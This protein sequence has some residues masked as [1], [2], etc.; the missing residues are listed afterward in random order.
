VVLAAVIVT[1]IAVILALA[2]L[3]AFTLVVA[4]I[5]A[6]DRRLSLRGTSRSRPDAFARWVLGVRPCQG[7]HPART[8][9]GRRLPWA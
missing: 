1:G 4:G 2:L 9:G 5:R 3:T 6:T 7:A 8:A